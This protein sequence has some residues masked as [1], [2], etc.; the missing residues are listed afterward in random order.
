LC[1]SSQSIQTLT[2]EWA[3]KEGLDVSL[4]IRGTPGRVIAD[5]R[6][7]KQILVNLIRNAIAFSSVGSTILLGAERSAND[8]T[9]TLWV[10]DKGTGIAVEDQSHIL[11]PFARG[12]NT[13]GDNSRV[14][15]GNGAGLGLTLVKNITEIHG[16]QMTIDSAPGHGTTVTLTLPVVQTRNP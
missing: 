9:I 7:L 5:P 6:R 11:E 4:D 3:R 10:E 1:R 8:Q 15:Q 13:R 2:Q 16:G 14:G 12:G